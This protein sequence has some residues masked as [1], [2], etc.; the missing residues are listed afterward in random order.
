MVRCARAALVQRARDEFFSGAGFAQDADSGFAGGD[1]FDLG[2]HAAHGLA[3]PDDFVFAEAALQIAVLAFEASELERVFDRE[4]KL[5]G[6]DRL[7]EEI[8]R[9]KARGAHSHL[10]VRLA[11]HHDDGG[12]HALRFEFFEQ[13]ESVFAGHDD[14]GEDEVEG[15]RFGEFEG[16]VGVVADGGFV[17]FE[18][19]SARKRGQRIGFVVDDQQVCFVAAR[20]CL[21]DCSYESIYAETPSSLRKP[22]AGRREIRRQTSLFG[23][24]G[25]SMRN[26]VPFSLVLSTEILPPW[27]LTTD[28]TMARPSPV[29][30]CLVV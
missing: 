24:I 28:C 8:E 7:F 25:S 9:A 17:A 12:L 10:D 14:V 11:R 23:W 3:F 4:K 18:T 19:E 2:H 20:I 22:S 1:A 15:L 30:C 27:S 16:F 29:P 13:S 21:S 26:V 5:F 6:G